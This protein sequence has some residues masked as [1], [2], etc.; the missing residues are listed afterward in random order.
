LLFIPLLISLLSIFIFYISNLEIHILFL[1]EKNLTIL[2]SFTSFLISYFIIYLLIE[3]FSIFIYKKRINIIETFINVS[4]I[5]IPLILFSLIYLLDILLGYFLHNL[6]QGW[7][8]KAL[9][10]LF[11]IWSVIL[12]L[13]VIKVTKGLS[14]EKSLFIVLIIIYINLVSSFILFI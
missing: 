9:F 3:F 12:L 8:L 2:Q 6:F 14:L 11:Q 13:N 5:F 4:I 10:L 1:F 7:I